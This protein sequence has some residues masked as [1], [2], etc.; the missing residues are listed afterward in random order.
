[1]Y[2]IRYQVRYQAGHIIKKTTDTK[3]RSRKPTISLATTILIS[4]SSGYNLIG[5]HHGRSSIK[6]H[7]SL[8]CYSKF[9]LQMRAK[10]HEL[11]VSLRCHLSKEFFSRSHNDNIIS[12]IHPCGCLLKKITSISL[13]ELRAAFYHKEPDL[14]NHSSAHYPRLGERY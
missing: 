9:D 14:R 4:P 12:I 1:M 13:R 3:P 8:P 5:P 10:S 11:I 2:L 7:M 6:V